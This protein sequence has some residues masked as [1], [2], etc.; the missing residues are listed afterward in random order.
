MK[1]TFD[2]DV[3]SF[4]RRYDTDKTEDA[5][6]NEFIT[7][8]LPKKDYI[9]SLSSSHLVMFWLSVYPD[10]YHTNIRFSNDTINKLS[11]FGIELNVEISILKDIYEGRTEWLSGQMD[12]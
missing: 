2:E 3:F 6:I 5:A 9:R 10:E 11:E 1:V 4:D 12:E 8:L 7:E